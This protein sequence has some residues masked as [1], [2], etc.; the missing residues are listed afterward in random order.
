MEIRVD[1]LRQL[2]EQMMVYGVRTQSVTLDEKGFQE[3]DPGARGYML[4]Q[5][6]YAKEL[7]NIKN[8]FREK[9]VYAIRDQLGAW[10]Y[11]F[12][13]PYDKTTG[14]E[15]VHVGPFL[16]EEPDLLLQKISENN[17]LD[18]LRKRELE[19]YYYSM[20]RLPD[21]KFLE[22]LLVLQVSLIYGEKERIRIEHALDYYGKGSVKTVPASVKMLQKISAEAL[23]ERYALEEELLTAVAKGDR[24]AAYAVHTRLSVHSPKQRVESTRENQKYMLLSEN[25]LYRKAVQ[26]AGVHPVH[27]DRLS[28][29]FV[30]RLETCVFEKELK[31]LSREMIRRYC[32]LVKKYALRGYSRVVRDALNYIDLHLSEP[33]SL[34]KLSQA[35]SI[36]ASY[37]SSRFKKEVGQSVMEY[38]NERR[39]LE[40]RRYL[41]ITDLSVGEIAGMVGV[42]DGNY[43]TKLFKKYH[44]CTPKEYRNIIR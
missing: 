38:I 13:L 28:S 6:D 40:S 12:L 19:E 30:K 18:I 37:L 22:G 8:H 24:A 17:Q 11:F 15:M 34:K 21:I 31:E 4:H 25:T 14:K 10:N 42:S 33:L 29:Y 5:L 23:E 16:M 9:T 7:N 44:N 27:I 39:I 1:P 3:F 2:S 41:A 35:E 36:S 43:F 32:L 20:P 26:A